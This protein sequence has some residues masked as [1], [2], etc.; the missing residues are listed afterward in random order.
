MRPRPAVLE[1]LRW[2]V[3]VFYKSSTISHTF[4]VAIVG[5]ECPRVAVHVSATVITSNGPGD[6]SNVS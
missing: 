2:L 6:H 4:V 3:D 5:S 1:G